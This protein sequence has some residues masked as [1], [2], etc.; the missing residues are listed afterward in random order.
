M[1]KKEVKLNRR[2]IE[3][4][5]RF[6]ARFIL[7]ITDRK[8]GADF[9]RVILPEGANL[10]LANHVTNG[11]Q[12]LMSSHFAKQ[13]LLFVAGENGFTNKFFRW[14]IEKKIGAIVHMRGV[15]L[16]STIKQ[17]LTR[18]KEGYN[19]CMFPE[20]STTFTGR[21]VSVDA[22]IA[23][24]AKS[25]GANLILCRIEGGYLTRP[26]WGETIRKGRIDIIDHI[27]TADELAK[28]SVNEITDLINGKLYE[29][30]YASQEKNP[31]KYIGKNPCKGLESCIYQCPGCKKF[32][33][34]ST[35]ETRI[36]CDCGFS[37][38]YDEYG[39]LT[40]EAGNKHT[41]SEWCD[42]Q[43]SDLKKL[44][45]DAAAS[46]ESVWIFSDELMCKMVSNRGHR[47]TFGKIILKAFSDK[48][49]YTVDG[50][51]K[52]LS[53]SDIKSAFVYL[54]NTMNVQIKDKDMS[55][56]LTGDFS[57]NALK[58]KDLLDIVKEK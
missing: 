58:Y 12:F 30:A 54:R 27:V 43:K 41:V 4:W 42:E 16:I 1:K 24:L 51:E 31:I 50:K 6:G 49:T 32:N 10:I 45:L 39:Y 19:V 35:S 33:R 29:D 8:F 9:G 25:S 55:F 52:E 23:K 2:T 11:D 14:F 7:P 34:L 20:G 5:H 15:S 21:T 26:R 13:P 53:Y 47:R 48:L 17:M 36:S 28:M 22:A 37:A 38:T 3:R 57:F 44:V 18:L 56:E 40:D 46:G